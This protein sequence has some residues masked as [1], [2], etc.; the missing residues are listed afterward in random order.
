MNYINRVEIS[1][2][3]SEVRVSERG[4][5]FVML[6]QIVNYNGVDYDRVFELIVNS[7]KQDIIE[8]LT[9]GKQATF[10]GAL[11]IFKIKKFNIHKMIVD[12]NQMILE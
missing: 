6:K 4:T 7:N 3:I 2:V 5:R 12:V 11:T 8:K 10:N 1:G 9:I